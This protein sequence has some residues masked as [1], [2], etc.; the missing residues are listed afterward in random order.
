MDIEDKY[1]L[2]STEMPLKDVEISFR[3]FYLVGKLSSYSF[4][5]LYL[6]FFLKSFLLH[7]E[8][9]HISYLDI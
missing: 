9:Y 1:A 6:I 3:V 5:Y 4:N 8:E 2:S 7:L